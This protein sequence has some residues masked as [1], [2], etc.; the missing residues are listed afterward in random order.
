MDIHT[1]RSCKQNWTSVSVI[2][3]ERTWNSHFPSTL[4]LLKQV[5]WWN[6]TIYD[7]LSSYFPLPVRKWSVLATGSNRETKWSSEGRTKQN[8]T[9]QMKPRVPSPALVPPQKPGALLIQPDGLLVSDCLFLELAFFNFVHKKTN[10]DISKELH[11]GSETQVILKFS[12]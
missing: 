7:P 2:C 4:L 11:L 1:Q 12:Q 9:K 3:V 5:W 10:P 6:S 8:N